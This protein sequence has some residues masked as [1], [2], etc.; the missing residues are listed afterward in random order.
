MLTAPSA[1][2]PNDEACNGICTYN[3]TTD[4]LTCQLDDNGGT[5][6]AAAQAVV[7]SNYYDGV[8]TWDYAAWG[9][10]TGGTDFSCE[11]MSTGTNP[12]DRV[13][14]IGG[15]A[16]DDLCFQDDGRGSA[17][18]TLTLEIAG[19]TTVLEAGDDTCN[20]E[21][22]SDIVSGGMDDDTL[23]GGDDN[24]Y[25][26]GNNGTNTAVGGSGSDDCDRPQGDC[27]SNTFNQ[28]SVPCPW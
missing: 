25:M 2:P 16:A 13:V 21:G 14:L 8:T 23:N 1:P 22:G 6:D 5:A 7:V 10:S 20:G 19:S 3:S 26:D 15:T 24:D 9:T 17:F 27:E 28:S 12:I 11:Y 18:S 4:D